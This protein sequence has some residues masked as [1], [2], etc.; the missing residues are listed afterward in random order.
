[1]YNICVSRAAR[2][3]DKALVVGWLDELEKQKKIHDPKNG[4][5][6]G[7]VTMA[8]KSMAGKQV[9]LMKSIFKSKQ[10]QISTLDWTSSVSAS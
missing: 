6:H 10:V 3:T 5:K 8:E 1:M 4:G 2:K 7:A 9:K